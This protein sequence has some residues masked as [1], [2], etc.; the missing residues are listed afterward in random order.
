MVCLHFKP[1]VTQGQ[2]GSNDTGKWRSFRLSIQKKFGPQYA[3]TLRWGE[4]GGVRKTPDGLMMRFLPPI[5]WLPEGLDERERPRPYH[6]LDTAAL[7]QWH[8]E[9][10][11]IPF[12][13][14]KFCHA[15]GVEYKGRPCHNSSQYGFIRSG[16]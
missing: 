8:E 15:Y 5:V 9:E 4:R 14:D 6:V 1:G 7:G 2:G 12:R 13:E 16:L 11:L 3:V 10:Y